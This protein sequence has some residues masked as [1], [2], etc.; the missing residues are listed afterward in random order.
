M[1]RFSNALAAAG[2]MGSVLA[3]PGTA[4]ALDGSALLKRA[5]DTMGDPRTVRFVAQGTGYTYGQAYV[6]RSE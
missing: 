3:L 2:L 5:S 6:P 4:L 1:F